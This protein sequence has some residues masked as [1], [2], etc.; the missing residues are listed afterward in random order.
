MK[1]KDYVRNVAKPEGSI[2]E[3]YVVDQALTVCLR[4]FNDLEIGFNQPNMNDDGM[5]PTRHLSMF[6]S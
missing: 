3:G 1:V 5:H 4:Y 6:E 2:F